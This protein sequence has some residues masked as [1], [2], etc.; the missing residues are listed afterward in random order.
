MLFCETY[1]SVVFVCDDKK[2]ISYSELWHKRKKEN[3]CFGG[4]CHPSF[5]VPERAALSAHGR[6]LTY[7]LRDGGERRG[8]RS[9]LQATRKITACNEERLPC[10]QGILG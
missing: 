8:G 10:Q 7:K 1:V 9:S 6:R 5:L 3:H 4:L 2:S